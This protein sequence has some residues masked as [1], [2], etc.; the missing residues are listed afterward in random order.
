MVTPKKKAPVARLYKLEAET[1]K[2]LMELTRL[3]G[4]YD[5]SAYIRELIEVAYVTKIVQND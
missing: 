1:V 5:Q 2:K 3:C 4:M